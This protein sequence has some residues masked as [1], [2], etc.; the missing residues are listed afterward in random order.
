MKMGLAVSWNHSRLPKSP[1]GTR[2][3]KATLNL[4][5]LLLVSAVTG[6]TALSPALAQDSPAAAVAPAAITSI[7]LDGTNIVVSAQVPAGTRLVTLECRERLGP[8]GWEPRAVARLD[9]TG[10]EVRF[11]LARGF[12]AE[13]MRIRAETAAPLPAAFYAGTNEFFEIGSAGDT[14]TPPGGPL[15]GNQTDATAGTTPSTS[16]TT[17]AVEE[18]DIWKIHGRTLYFFNQLRGLQV[19]DLAN[20]D[21][22]E[23]KGTLELPAAGEDLYVLEGGRV[24][25]L[26]RSGC[27]WYRSQVLIVDAS[28]PVTPRTA[29]TL[30]VTGWI[31]ES[32]LV[33]TALYVAS[34]TYRP[35]EKSNNTTWEWGTLVSSIDLADP[36][37][38][39][40]RDTR[41]L[42]G[43]GN[44]VTAT[45]RLLFVVTQDPTDWWQSVVQCIDITA[46]DGTMRPA[47]SV[48]TAGRVPDKFKIRWQDGVLTT[49]S[50]DW[51]STATRRL[52]TKLE[53]FRLPDPRAA[54]PLGIAKLGELELGRGEQLHATRFDGNRAYVVTFFRID[55]LWVVDLSNPATPRIAGSVD[56]P[57]WS[58]FIQPLGDKLVSI[59]IETNKVA[60]SLFDVKNPAAPALLSRVRLGQ[61]W[62]YS[63]ANWD[64]KAFSI[65]PEA[66][67]IL[68]PYTGDTRNGYASSVQLID[69]KPDAVVARGVITQQF[70]P[71]RATLFQDRILSLSEWQLLSVDAS[72]RDQPQLK[73]TLAL[74]WTVDRVFLHGD[75]L[76]ELGAAAS[77]GWTAGSSAPVLRST[78]AESPGRTLAQL[79]LADL[80]L[81]GA[82]QQGAHLFLLQGD[83]GGVYYPPIPLADGTVGTD[84]TPKTRPAKVLLTAI[85]LSDLPTLTVA[86]Q[87]SAETDPL[88]FI[89]GFE[90]VWPDPKTLVFAG[91]GFS[92]FWD[93]LMCP[94]P[95]AVDAMAVDAV[96]GRGL[97]WPYRGGGNGRLLAFTVSDPAHPAFASSVILSSN[98][99][100]SFSQPFAA[101]GLVYVSHQTSEFIPLDPA[102]PIPLDTA[103]A[104]GKAGAIANPITPI[105]PDPPTGY[106]ASR[107]FLDVVDYASAA[108]PTV[109]R[110]VSIPGRLN[111]VSHHGAV[112]YTVGTHWR[113]GGTEDGTEYLDAAA[114]DG[115]SVHRVDSL[116]LSNSWPRSLL[117][118]G[119]TAFVGQA[120]PAIPADL[121]GSTGTRLD[122]WRLSDAGKFSRVGKLGLAAPVTTL[123]RFGDLLVA[124]R[125]DSGL[126]LLDASQPAGLRNVGDGR[127][128]GCLY[129]D[130]LHADG[131]LGRG[132]WLPL[133]A[134]G[135]ARLPL[136]R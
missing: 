72:D 115:V 31:V 89:S 82:V 53:T 134:Y 45:D 18:S 85:S 49:I 95:M 122:S 113:K 46:P 47:G 136:T 116:P 94:V 68:V 39:V 16:T 11:R 3:L 59:G 109:R 81:L 48:R 103:T 105:W 125:T 121:P 1:R 112:I 111:G 70:Q 63:E 36:A 52:T 38:P 100:W 77:W 25:L 97:F 35:V 24:V 40:A 135:A 124:Q 14:R 90:A 79:P 71:R 108:H 74:A 98:Q 106:W 12:T 56:V 41:W 51:R 129:P 133:G 118:A 8:G 88:N 86:G 93:C 101:Q 87:V 28:D 33:G 44:V 83:S 2:P 22:P 15:A 102:T 78:R 64:E 17:R 58:T 65:L 7:Q 6:V 19:I 4:T 9:G 131:Q 73:S 57:G 117:I 75:H 66:G 30:D 29:A 55:P 43:Y 128:P 69:L 62:S 132:L 80:P 20:P 37:R 26:A 50:E 127:L 130:L 27:D 84:G 60:V 126:F 10:G 76:V 104:D 123:A 107:S 13:L 54:G 5:L 67:L 91:S 110:P 34:Q 32:R 23:L 120:D 99:W 61:N 119:E 21:R 92:Y 42:A 96:V 114:Y